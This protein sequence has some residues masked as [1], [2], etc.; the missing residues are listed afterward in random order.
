VNQLERF[1]APVVAD[2]ADVTFLAFHPVR[3]CSAHTA[4]VRLVE[5]IAGQ[6]PGKDGNLP[7]NRNNQAADKKIDRES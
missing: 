4:G 1:T 7:I 2:V 6:G 3:R 5:V